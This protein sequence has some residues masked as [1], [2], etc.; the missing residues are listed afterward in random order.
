MPPAGFEPTVSAGELPQ[1][2]ALYRADT[3][4][5]IQLLKSR[6]IYNDIFRFYFY[7]KQYYLSTEIAFSVKFFVIFLSCHKWKL[8]THSLR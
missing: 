8:I 5:G 1:T 3:G 6:S 7:I 4:I 2:H